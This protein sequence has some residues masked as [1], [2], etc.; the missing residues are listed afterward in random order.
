MEKKIRRGVRCHLIKDGYIICTKYALDS[1]IRYGWFDIPGGRIEDGENAYEACIREFK[2]KTG[3]DVTDLINKGN[4][5]LEYPDRIYEF[6][7]FFAR[8]YRGQPGN[9][10]E[11][12][13]CWINID[14]LLSSDK[15]VSN[16]FV[17]NKFFLKSF[18]NNNNTFTLHLLVDDNENILNIDYTLNKY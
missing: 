15:I 14:E 17:L 11:N 13:S 12:T 10:K 9:F 2:G 4:I 3:M 8:G 1:N 16:I 5:I 6:S 18:L 7:A